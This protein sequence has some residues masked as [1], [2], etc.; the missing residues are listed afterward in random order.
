MEKNKQ[1]TVKKM[2]KLYIAI[3]YLQLESHRNC[4]E[5]RT[6]NKKEQ[7][8]SRILYIDLKNKSTAYH[9]SCPNFT[10]RI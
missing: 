2:F 7:I 10:I 6:R 4:D 5:L 8:I 1:C 3:H 9:L